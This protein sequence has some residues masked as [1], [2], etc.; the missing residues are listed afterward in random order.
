MSTD[1]NKK[2]HADFQ[3][4]YHQSKNFNSAAKDES[5]KPTGK[6]NVKLENG[7]DMSD[8]DKQKIADAMDH[9]Q[10]KYENTD[11][12]EASREEE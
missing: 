9:M 3:S 1:K 2:D 11:E 7:E 10:R 4:E 12:R 6:G 5:L 8:S